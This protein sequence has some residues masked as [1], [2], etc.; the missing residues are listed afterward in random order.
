MR[1]LHPIPGGAANGRAYVANTIALRRRKGTIAVIERLAQDVTG[2][3]SHAVEFFQRLITT[4]NVN[5]VRPDSLATVDLGDHAAL[6]RL[7]GPF[8]TAQHTLDVRRVEIGRGKYN[9]PNIGVFLWRLRAFPAENVPATPAIEIGAGPGFFRFS[10][11]G[12]DLVLFCNPADPPT[13]IGVRS[14]E[15]DM[16]Q[17]LDRRTLFDRLEALRRVPVVDADLSDPEFDAIL[18]VHKDGEPDPVKP[19]E[20]PHLQSLDLPAPARPHRLRPRTL[21]RAGDARDQGGG[22]S[23]ARL[24]GPARR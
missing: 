6:R 23:G 20:I 21:D 14:R 24:A 18:L 8:E 16:P 17:A 15:D 12:Q 11:L 9:V 7:D 1:S 22:G 13:E 3:P 2:W 4:Q 19:G 10:Q 5:H